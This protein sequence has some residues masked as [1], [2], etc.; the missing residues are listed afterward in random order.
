MDDIRV[1]SLAEFLVM[2]L[3]DG[4]VLSHGEEEYARKELE[5]FRDEGFEV[6]LYRRVP[7]PEEGCAWL[8]AMMEDDPEGE[9]DEEFG[10]PDIGFEPDAEYNPEFA[11][12]DGRII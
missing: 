8:T 5:D 1:E 7:E 6:S 2:D 11:D 9:P 3:E 12:L 4:V 10:G